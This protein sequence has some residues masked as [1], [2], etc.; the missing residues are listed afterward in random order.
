MTSKDPYS[1]ISKSLPLLDHMHRFLLPGISRDMA[2]FMKEKGVK[3]VLDVACGTGYTVC[4]LHRKGIRVD[5]VDMS[6]EMLLLASQKAG[7]CFFVRGDGMNLPF[8]A[9]AFDAALVSLALHEMSPSTREAVWSE[10]KRA[11]RPG[12]L[13]FILDFAKLPGKRSLF[14]RAV[15]RVIL[16]VEKSTLKFDPDH[17]HNSLHFQAQGA[18]PGWLAAAGDEPA[19]TWSYLGG[20]LVLAVSFNV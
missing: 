13:L 16:A 11:V 2:A 18:L 12:G 7:D 4:A 19:R 5:G 10:M 6:R 17:W 8:K 20:N 9:G 14:S 15:A 3:R 1:A